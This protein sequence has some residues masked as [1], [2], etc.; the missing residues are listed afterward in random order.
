LKKL[1]KRSLSLV[2]GEPEGIPSGC[3]GMAG[4]LGYENKHY[5][6]SMQIGGLEMSPAINQFI[7]DTDNH[8]STS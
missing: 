5:D 6:I 7:V 8:L 1:L 4:A 2:A 3:F